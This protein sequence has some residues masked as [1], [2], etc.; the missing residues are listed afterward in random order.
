MATA[1]NHW[2]PGARRRSNTPEAEH[3]AIRTVNVQL[4]RIQVTFD[5]GE[6]SK[7]C[8]MLT[9]LVFS[10]GKSDRKSFQFRMIETARVILRAQ[11]HFDEPWDRSDDRFDLENLEIYTLFDDVLMTIIL[12]PLGYPYRDI[13][14][15]APCVT[16][17]G[18]G[19]G[20]F[21]LGYDEED[22]RIRFERLTA[23]IHEHAAD[24]NLSNAELEALL[25]R[26]YPMIDSH[27]PRYMK[28]CFD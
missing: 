4:R 11:N 10:T 16:E 9:D 12:D 15:V 28:F 20:Y 8:A 26:R 21:R 23:L 13:Y 1:S 27:D 25:E 7:A 2:R 14:R 5:R 19:C 17:G 22:E 18:S 6:R 3:D 24:H